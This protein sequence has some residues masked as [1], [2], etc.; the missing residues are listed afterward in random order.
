MG[1]PT[2]FMNIGRKEGGYRPIHERTG[3]FGEVEQTLNDED[4]RAQASRCMDCGVPFC[5]WACPVHGKTP[6]WQDALYRG[7][8][9]EAYEILTST[10]SF[11]EFTGRV[12][13]ALCE[14]SCVLNIHGEAVTSRENE[15][16]VIEKSF[17]LGLVQPRIPKMRTGKKVAVIGAG[18][19]GLASADML[20]QMGHTVVVYEADNAIGG[21]LRYG[22]PDFKL[23]K[24]IIDRRQRIMEAEGIEF[25][26]STKAGVDIPFE[27]LDRKYD[28]ICV[29][30]GS[31]IPRDLPA[32]GRELPGVHF[33]LELLQQQNRVV[34]GDKFDEKERISAEGKHVLVIGGGDTGSDC[35]GT[36]IRQKAL[37]VTQIEIMPKPSV[38]RSADNPWPYWPNVLRT[39]SSH[40]EGCERRWN[41]AT[42]RFVEENG[43]LVGADVV[44]VE[45][46]KDETGRMQM[47][48]I[49]GT[50][51]FI[52]AELILLSMGFVHPE[53]DG[54][55]DDMGAEYD[56]R[57]NVKTANPDQTQSTFNQK[58][59]ACGDARSG[60]SLVVRAIA[61]GRLGAQQIN[62]FLLG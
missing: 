4:R 58:V 35:V 48:E 36:S 54:L 14:K 43:K 39:S 42:K 7:N 44:Q 20:N 53:H 17:E 25:V 23:N 9:K 40:L 22:I 30:I 37:S 19:S 38:Q 16:A 45:W 57:G 10:N 52:K 60:A 51:E 61:N 50:E 5:H 6:E 29:C 47:H 3:D 46:V 32:P 59:F 11:P 1:N 24:M 12:C 26:V 2:G 56:G 8:Y 21:L 34:R 49:A 18:P 62:S 28:A 15:C 41:L 13:P 55:L 33:A 27:E 31:R